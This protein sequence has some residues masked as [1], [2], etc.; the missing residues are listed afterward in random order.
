MKKSYN[1]ERAK[2]VKEKLEKNK[3]KKVDV[4]KLKKSIKQKQN[5]DTIYK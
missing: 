4:E 1:T 2:Q 5:E 3:L